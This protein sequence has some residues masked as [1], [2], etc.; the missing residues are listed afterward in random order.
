MGVYCR[1]QAHNQDCT[2]GL[3]SK[4]KIFL[5]EKCLIWTKKFKIAIANTH[6]PKKKNL[7]SLGKYIMIEKCLKY[8]CTICVFYNLPC[9]RY[10]HVETCIFTVKGTIK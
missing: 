1:L 10:M 5:F 7:K 3:D 2:R 9:I 6:P 8:M 4:I